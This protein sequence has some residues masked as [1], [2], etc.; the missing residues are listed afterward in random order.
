MNVLN[1]NKIY[2]KLDTVDAAL[3]SSYCD[4]ELRKR[5]SFAYATQLGIDFDYSPDEIHK[6]LSSLWKY[7]DSTTLREDEK[8]RMQGPYML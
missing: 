8:I 3:L 1:V 4:R 7:I 2:W 6:A 5:V